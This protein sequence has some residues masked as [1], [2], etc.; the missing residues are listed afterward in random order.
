M[1]NKIGCYC[2]PV[3]FSVVFFFVSCA[4]LCLFL[5]AFLPFSPVFSQFLFPRVV[6]NRVNRAN[7]LRERMAA[8]SIFLRLCVLAKIQCGDLI[9][10]ARY[11]EVPMNSRVGSC[12]CCIRGPPSGNFYRQQMSST[13]RWNTQTTLSLAQKTMNSSRTGILIVSPKKLGI[14]IHTSRF[15]LLARVCGNS[16][17][18]V[19]PAG[20]FSCRCSGMRLSCVAFS[21]VLQPTNRFR[22]SA[23]RRIT[24]ARDPSI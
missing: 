3:L 9:L 6:I 23:H 10:L 13:A 16:P 7:A 8:F 22:R 14:V 18:L 19:Y 12:S 21:G 17:S 1:S 4:F 24:F 5:P 11:I 2:F 15:S 20:R